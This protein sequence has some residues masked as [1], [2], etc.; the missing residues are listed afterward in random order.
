MQD[1]KLISRR[2]FVK[3]TGAAALGASIIGDGLLTAGEARAD[4]TPRPKT[5]DEALKKLM[6]GNKRFADSLKKSPRRT[7]EVREQLTGG[8]A[9]FAAILACAD[10]RVAPEII[11]DQGLGDLFVVRV[12]GNIVNTANYGIVGSLEY[13][14]MAL[15]AHIIMVLGHSRCGAVSSAIEAVEKGAEFP[16]AIDDIVNSIGPAVAA[17]KDAPGNLLE[18]A[19]VA[20]VKLGVDMLN[21]SVPVLAD[22]VREG[23]LKIVGANYDLFTGE[24]KIVA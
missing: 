19:T 8:Q 1:S 2:S 20:N 5:P 16:G 3:F 18:N 12:A 11:F 23:K 22:R 9:P 24:V 10:S 15:G 17:A 14:A 4:E 21:G 7:V 6:D 13:G